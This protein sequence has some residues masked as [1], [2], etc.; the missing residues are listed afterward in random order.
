MNPIH[1]D[2]TLVAQLISFILLAFLV[3]GV[4]YFVF[5]FNRHLKRTKDISEK[6]DQIIKLLERNDYK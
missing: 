1:I 4:V 2:L 5:F 6:L 3:F